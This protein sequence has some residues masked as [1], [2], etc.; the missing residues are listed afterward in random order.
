MNC[1]HNKKNNV[2][3]IRAD[4][5]VQQD[6]IDKYRAQ[7]SKTIDD[8]NAEINRLRNQNSSQQDEKTS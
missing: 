7:V 5:Q 6:N 3:Q 8:A 2:T 1:L 4:I